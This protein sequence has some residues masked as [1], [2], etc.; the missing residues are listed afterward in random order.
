[1]I[2]RSFLEKVEEMSKVEQ[3]E[4]HGKQYATKQLALVKPAQVE[5]IAIDT[6]QGLVDFLSANKDGI[7]LA[8]ATVHVESHLKV[9]VFGVPD[10]TYRLRERFAIASY[11]PREYRY[12]QYVTIE[13]F[14]VGLQTYF[15]VDETVRGILQ[16]LGNVTDENVRTVS[17]DGITQSVTAKTGITLRSEVKIPNPV[18][19]APHCT[20]REVEQP[21][22]QFILRLQRQEG[23]LPACALFDADGGRWELEAMARIQ[24]WLKE[25]LPDM[26]VLA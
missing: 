2:D 15:V 16:V 25:R 21:G 3:F 26:T 22:R 24:S 8:K 7:D 10:D 18:V 12:G 19:L 1:M 17:D 20:F 4:I 6:L 9:S 13:D 11:A 14:L 23:K 5:P